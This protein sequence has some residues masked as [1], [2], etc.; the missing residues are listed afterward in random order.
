M[1]PHQEPQYKHGKIAVMT[2]YYSHP[3]VMWHPPVLGA[4]CLTN[5]CEEVSPPGYLTQLCQEHLVDSS[6]RGSQVVHPQGVGEAGGE[7]GVKLQCLEG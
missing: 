6:A 4:E 7:G 5:G 2:F 3:G 1:S